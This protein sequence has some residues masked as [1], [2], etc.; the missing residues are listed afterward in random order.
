MQVLAKNDLIEIAT[1]DPTIK[2]DIRY[3]T[4]NNFLGRA[5]Y[6][7]AKAYLQKEVLED[8]IKLSKEIK[9]DGYGLLVYDGYRPWSVTK[10]FWDE[11]PHEKRQF[12]ADPKVGSNH[13]RGCA[14]DLTLYNLKTGEALPMPCDYD[15]FSRKAYPTYKSGTEEQ[16]KNRDYL[17]K[18]MEKHNFTVHRYEFWHFDHRSCKQYGV[19]DLPFEE[20]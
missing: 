2:L 18:K 15:T 20:I 11:I 10:I 12:V 6:K 7:Q 16:R 4:K 13:N 17:I 8:L 14:V 9:K 19:L 3:A 1:L 5:V